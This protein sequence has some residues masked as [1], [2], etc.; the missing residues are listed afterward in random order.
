MGQKLRF[1]YL[2]TII[3]GINVGEH[4]IQIL[5]I[6]IWVRIFLQINIDQVFYVKVHTIDELK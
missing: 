4:F 6:Y 1:Y 5:G 3:P 2:R